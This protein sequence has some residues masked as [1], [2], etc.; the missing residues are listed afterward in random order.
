MHR[1]LVQHSVER[2]DQPT[3]PRA[4]Q[5]LDHADDLAGVLG[6]TQGVMSCAAKDGRHVPSA[7]RVWHSTVVMMVMPAHVVTRW[8]L[9]A[10]VYCLTAAMLLLVDHRAAAIM[11]VVVVDI[12]VVVMVTAA[13]A[14]DIGAAATVVVRRVQSRLA[15]VI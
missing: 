9:R 3:R 11:I 8:I 5:L 2:D 12:I 15:G 14:T 10:G 13:A 7:L 4:H 1:Y 6:L